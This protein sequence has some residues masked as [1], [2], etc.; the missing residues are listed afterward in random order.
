VVWFDR[1]RL[2][3]GSPGIHYSYICILC[4]AKSF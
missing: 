2:G 3:I 4:L 1:P